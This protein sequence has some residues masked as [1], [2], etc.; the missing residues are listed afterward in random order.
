MRELH[1]LCT[2]HKLVV[3]ARQTA[4]RVIPVASA[5]AHG[6]ILRRQDTHAHDVTHAGNGSCVDLV[7]GQ[8]IVHQVLV[9]GEEQLA[10]AHPQVYDRGV[11]PATILVAKRQRELV[12]ADGHERLDAVAL[13]CLEHLAVV[14]DARLQW[15]GVVAVGEDAAPLRGEAEALE[16]HL[17]K[18]V[19]VLLKVM[20]EVDGLVA[21]V[22]DSLLHA[23]RRNHARLVHR[24]ARDDVRHAEALAVRVVAALKLVSRRRAAPQKPLGKLEICHTRSFLTTL[25][26]P[27]DYHASQ[28]GPTRPFPGRLRAARPSFACRISGSREANVRIK[29]CL[30]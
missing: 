12:V 13:A 21:G 22:V 18:E 8:P 16:A 20:V 14:V 1:G 26:A 7:E 23:R 2:C 15:L 10:E 28:D 27:Q 29:C 4:L 5:K 11:V 25:R 3:Q 19:D 17:A 24:A 6:H 9:L 30:L